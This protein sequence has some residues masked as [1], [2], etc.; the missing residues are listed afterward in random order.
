[1]TAEPPDNADPIAALLIA[2]DR[3]HTHVTLLADQLRNVEL[4]DEDAERA[5]EAV[6]RAFTTVGLIGSLTRSGP[7]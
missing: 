1:M 6:R 5:Q 7:P 3:F 4:S 2:C